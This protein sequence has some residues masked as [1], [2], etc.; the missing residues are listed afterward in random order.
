MITKG[1]NAACQGGLEEPWEANFPNI[2]NFPGMRNGGK[3][4]GD[5]G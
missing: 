4:T 1:A 5:D 3:V 2:P